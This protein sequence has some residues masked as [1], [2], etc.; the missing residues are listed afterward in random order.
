MK[1]AMT[2][3]VAVLVLLAGACGDD[4]VEADRLGVGAECSHDD[5]CLMEQSCLAFKGGYCGISGCDANDDC[6]EG[7]VCVAHDDGKTYCFRACT[8]KAE[9]NQNRSPD[10]ESNCSSS[11]DYVD[12][13]TQLK[14]CVP[15]S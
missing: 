7:S 10:N 14:A 11:I 12:T 4:S 6:P 13:T 3:L 15:P 8:D 9:C 5:D 1:N 2:C